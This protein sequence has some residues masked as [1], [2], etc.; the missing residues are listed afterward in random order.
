MVT[1]VDTG[2][3]SEVTVRR[4]DVE[5]YHR[6]GEAGIFTGE[7]R[8]EL[9]DGR[10]VEMSPIGAAHAN[11]IVWITRHLVNHF[12]SDAAVHVQNPLRVSQHDEVQPDLVVARSGLPRQQMLSPRDV[13]LVIE[14]SDTTLRYDRNVKLPLYARAGIGEFWIVDLQGMA[15]ERHS[16][17]AEGGY[18]VSLRV[19][20][21]REIESLA[22]PGLLFSVGEV[23]G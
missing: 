1:E 11:C 19:E 18:Q 9:V 10:I 3:M 6:M 16:E 13:I 22:A 20:R 2:S 7:D 15:I 4:F 8:V 12:G 21:G 5:A 23:L 17:P 14:V